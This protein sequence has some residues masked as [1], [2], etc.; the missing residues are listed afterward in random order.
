MP[1][2]TDGTFRLQFTGSCSA[3]EFRARCAEQDYWYHS[4]YFD[5]GFEQRGDYDIGRDIASYGFPADMSGMSVLDVGTGGGW[6]ATYFEQRGADVTTVDLRGFADFDV[7]GRPGYPDI[8]EEKPEPDVRLPDGRG[9]YFSPVSKG[10]W[11]MKELLGLRAEYANARVYELSPALFSGR[12][13]ELVF[14]GAVLMHLR[15]PIG[16]LMAI[17]TVAHGE[18]IA[19][20]FLLEGG[21]S[22]PPRMQLLQ[23]DR[24]SW[25]APNRRCLESWFRGAGFADVELTGSVRL[26]PDRPYVD[27]GGHSSAVEQ[28]FARV[29]A[30]A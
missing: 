12:K 29:E 6:F 5:N 22:D 25:W 14:V 7:F 16:A 26:R 15:D 23:G 2:P 1:L 21:P 30:R 13:F 27:A 18:V 4:Y 3:D 9:L 28:V 11:I 10:F 17:R 20:S 19:T 24:I 8:S